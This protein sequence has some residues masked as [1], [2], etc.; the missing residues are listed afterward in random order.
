MKSKI[1][2]E[3]IKGSSIDM[4]GSKIE[5]FVIIACRSKFIT[6]EHPNHE[7]VRLLIRKQ[8]YAC[9]IILLIQFESS[10]FLLQC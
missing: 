3:I 7:S 10:I 1:Q 6:K 4:Q 9:I 5:T 8:I 2:R